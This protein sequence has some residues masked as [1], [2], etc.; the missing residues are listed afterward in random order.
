MGYLSEKCQKRV[1]PCH[2]PA[3]KILGDIK[4]A[5]VFAE[6]PTVKIPEHLIAR[7]IGLYESHNFS[8][9]V[10]DSFSHKFLPP[11]TSESESGGVASCFECVFLFVEGRKLGK[12]QHIVD[13]L[14]GFIAYLFDA[15]QLN[16]EL[17]KA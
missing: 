17:G 6:N 13:P 3:V 7:G 10:F 8:T 11:K 16:E 12:F 5:V 9:P 2:L 15:T 14:L 4:S 1:A